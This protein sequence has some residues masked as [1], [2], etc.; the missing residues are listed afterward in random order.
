MSYPFLWFLFIESWRLCSEI[1]RKRTDF[2]HPNIFASKLKILY[3]LHNVTVVLQKFCYIFPT[4]FNI[5]SVLFYCQLKIIWFSN[6]H[7]FLLFLF[8]FIVSNSKQM[9]IIFRISHFK[10][11]HNDSS[12]R[13]V[14][15]IQKIRKFSE[16]I[17]SK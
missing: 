4:L 8:L 16:K 17:M 7:F 5:E 6:L 13:S 10:K 1:I 2:K 15:P 12:A 9:V 11:N 14:F 3:F